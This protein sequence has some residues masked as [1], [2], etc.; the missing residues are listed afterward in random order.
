MVVQHGWPSSLDYD[1]DKTVKRIQQKYDA[2][3]QGSLYKLEEEDEDAFANSYTNLV[4]NFWIFWCIQ[5]RAK[6]YLVL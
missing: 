5:L 4:H 3:A 6:A 1:N 2:E